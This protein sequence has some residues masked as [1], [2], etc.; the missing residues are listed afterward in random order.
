VSLESS[1]LI[2]TGVSSGIG[3]AVASLLADAGAS[4]V[5]LDRTEPATEPSGGYIQCD[6]GEPESLGACVR[7]L[8]QWIDGLANVA[9]L[10]GTADANA[11]G[12]VNFLGLRYLTEEMHA[13]A[14]PFPTGRQ[15]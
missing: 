13:C 2:V 1:Q 8:P 11:I 9:G 5:G 12:R 10:P 6:L 3:A 14:V 7:Q 4:V 15:V